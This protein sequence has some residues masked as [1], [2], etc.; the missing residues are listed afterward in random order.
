MPEVAG[1]PADG[2]TTRDAVKLG[3]STGAQPYPDTYDA[4]IDVVVAAVNAMVRTWPVASDALTYGPTPPDWPPYVVQGATMLSSR[5]WRRKD[6]PSGVEA[7]TDAGAL[8]VSRNDPDVAQ[9]LRI[10]AWSPPEVG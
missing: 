6:S 10:G 8:Y 9:L 7:F 5:L 3:L 4:R 1:L 2:P